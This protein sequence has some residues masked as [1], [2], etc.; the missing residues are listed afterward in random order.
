MRKKILIVGGVAGGA[1]T[2]ARLRRKDENAEIIMFEKGEFISFANCGLPYYVGGAIEKREALLL[3]TPES[4][5]NRFNV[6]VRIWNEVKSIN[7]EEKTVEV[8]NIKE[9]K[10]YTESYDI[11]VLSPGSMPIVPPIKGIDSPNVFSLWNIPDVDKIK[12]YVDNKGPKKAVVVGGGFIGLE[13]AENLHDRGLDVSLVEMADQVMAPI[14]F[15]LAQIVHEHMSTLGVSLHLGDGV[16]EFNYDN[17]TTTIELSS[18]NKIEADIVI[19]SIGIRPQSMIAKEAGLK[20]NERGGIV[21]DEYLK[22]SDESI[23]AIGDV[24]EVTDFVSKGKTM[25][26]LAGPA[27]KQG[28]ICADNIAGRKVKFKGTQGTSVAKVFD[29][30]V[31][32]TG[33]NEKLLQREGLVYGKDYHVS[34]VLPKSHAGYYPGAMSMTLKVLYDNE[35]KILGAQNVGYEGVEKRIDVIATAMRLGGTVYDLAELELSYAPPYSSAKDPVNMAGFVADNIREKQYK[36][37]LCRE[38]KDL[39]MNKA[40]LL[41]VRTELEAGLGKIENSTLIPV[42][43]LRKRLG[44]LD[45]NK[46]IVIYCAVGVRGYIASRIL[47]QNGFENVYNVLGG[48]T[49]YKSLMYIPK[50]MKNN[51]KKTETVEN[52]TD[53]SPESCKLIEINAKGLQCPG[54]I[55][56]VYKGLENAAPGDRLKIVAS[57]MGFATDIQAWCDKTGNK[58]HECKI[59]RREIEAVIIKG[60]AKGKKAEKSGTSL[61]VFSGDLDKAIATMII[62]NGAAAMGD[63]VTLFFTFWGLNIIRKKEKVS[64]KKDIVGNMFGKMMPRGASKLA[65]SQMNMGG[66]GSKLIKHVMKTNNVDMLEKMIEDAQKSGIKFIACNMSMELMGIQEKEL[67]DDVE[68]A[69]V[70]AFLNSADKASIN[71]F[72]S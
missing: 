55:M 34:L 58:L 47:K 6:D 13:M 63:E 3:Q 14:D 56:E 41:D 62:A 25:I 33:K 11:L 39:D 20:L 7:K 46:D 49:A 57:D 54:P 70:A 27:N 28:R 48:Y 71:M 65:L 19:F 53:P 32:A 31:S 37:M 66:M 12:D 17:G 44:E 35:G 18:G 30:T 36:P 23:Y 69:G 51:K 10:S 21:V 43:D 1:S 38:I 4:F 8:Y 52:I 50:T 24:I 68:L 2:A 29:M 72:M 64:T 5:N 42:D 45:K 59:N 16:K 9:K 61:V 22:T 15:E 40:V 60:G 26:P 67:I